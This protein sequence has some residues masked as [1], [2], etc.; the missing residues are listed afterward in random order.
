MN[1][2]NNAILQVCWSQDDTKLF[3]CSAD[4]TV[5]IWDV[6]ESKR[7]KKM[8]GHEGFVNSIDSTKKGTELV[9]E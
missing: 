5:S 4:K 8:K 1:G 7:I 6:F 3:S 2:H 9:R